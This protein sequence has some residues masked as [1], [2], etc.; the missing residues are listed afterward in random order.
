MKNVADGDGVDSEE[1]DEGDGDEDFVVA[2][3]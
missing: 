3:V 2:T 1:I